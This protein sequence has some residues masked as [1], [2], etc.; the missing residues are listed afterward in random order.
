MEA[1]TKTIVKSA[2]IISSIVVVSVVILINFPP[3]TEYSWET[4]PNR[5]TFPE[6]VDNIT[7]II[8]Y[9]PA[10][11]TE[12]KFEHVN[13]QDHYTTVFDLF[14]EVGA[15]VTYEIWWWDHPAFFITSINF[16]VEKDAESANWMYSI[17][18]DYVPAATNAVSPPADSIVRWYFTK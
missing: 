9:G 5:L 7:L 1:K 13:L 8:Y 6:S 18:G 12:E 11:G 10:N 3:Q 16:L 2:L 4:D 15:H 17:N 14:A